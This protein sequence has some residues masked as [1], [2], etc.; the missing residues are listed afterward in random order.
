VPPP[1]GEPYAEVLVIAFAGDA[2]AKAD[3]AFSVE[4]RSGKAGVVALVVG[5]ADVLALATVP[6]LPV[7]ERSQ[8]F[9][10][11]GILPVPCLG[12]RVDDGLVWSTERG[13]G[14][15]NT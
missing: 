13:Q 8:G 2:D 1:Y 10:G 6:S 7:P 15:G 4:G 12:L 9:G 14:S 11:D 5:N 3:V